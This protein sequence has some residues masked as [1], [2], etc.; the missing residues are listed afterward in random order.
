VADAP[1]AE[2]PGQHLGPEAGEQGPAGS[3]RAAA[4]AQTSGVAIVDT[5]G[6][7]RRRSR[8]RWSSRPRPPRLGDA[9]EVGCGVM[10]FAISP[11]PRT[12]AAAERAAAAG[13]A[14]AASAAAKAAL[15]PPPR[16][17]LFSAP[18]MIQGRAEPRPLRAPLRPWRPRRTDWLRTTMTMNRMSRARIGEPGP[19]GSASSETFEGCGPWPWPLRGQASCSMMASVPAVMPPSC[20]R[21]ELRQ[22]GAL[23]DDAGQG[24]GQ[25]RFQAVA[26]LEAHLPLGWARPAGS[27]RCSCPSRRCPRCGPAGSRSPRSRSPAGWARWRPPAGGRWSSPG[28]PAWSSGRPRPPATGSGR[29]RPPGRSGRETSGPAA[30]RAGL[31]AA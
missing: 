29:R 24:V 12:A 17:P 5:S 14:S 2:Q 18:R 10:R 27:R 25:D 22:D 1:A 30:R 31:K 6:A 16:P 4:V 8:R 13:E 20:R 11:A 9:V 23:D 21:A 7:R 26:D 19:S 28:F 3:S 15:Q